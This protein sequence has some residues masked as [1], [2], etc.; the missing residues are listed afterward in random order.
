MSDKQNSEI[1]LPDPKIAP[2]PGQSVEMSVEH[3]KAVVRALKKALRESSCWS[4]EEFLRML[5]REF[6]RSY[7]ARAGRALENADS[8]S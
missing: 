6:I 7:Q 1:R 5:S 8:P 2:P 3:P 4:F